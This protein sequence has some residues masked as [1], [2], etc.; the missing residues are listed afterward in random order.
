M[1]PRIRLGDVAVSLLARVE[2]EHGQARILTGYERAAVAQ[3][4]DIRGPAIIV[5][6]GEGRVVAIWA[7]EDEQSVYGAA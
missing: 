3:R 7:R 5:D 2:A 1:N 4:Y 6:V